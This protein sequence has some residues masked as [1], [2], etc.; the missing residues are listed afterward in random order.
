MVLAAGWLVCGVCHVII[1]T[2][3]ISDISHNI[4][5]NPRNR[6]NRNECILRIFFAF[7]CPTI[8]ERRSFIKKYVL[9]LLVLLL[10]QC[11]NT[12]PRSNK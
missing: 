10:L 2:A 6:K 7:F 1:I 4:D 5:G 3:V 9:L 12:V 8:P 11:N